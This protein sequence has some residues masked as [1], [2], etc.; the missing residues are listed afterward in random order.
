MA[1]GLMVVGAV[2]SACGDPDSNTGAQ[3]A[4]TDDTSVAST[5]AS[6]TSAQQVTV[7]LQADASA[8]PAA[9][10]AAAEFL[11]DRLIERGHEVVDFV[12]A[13]TTFTYT[14]AGDDPDAV[15]ELLRVGRVN[16]RAVEACTPG[17]PAGGPIT[18]PADDGS[19]DPT[20]SGLLPLVGGGQ[21]IVRPAAASGSVFEADAEAQII[22]G[23]WSVIVSLRPGADGLDPWNA[24]AT[25]C[26]TGADACPSKQLAI[27]V[28]GAIISAPT[29]N[30][31][32][33]AGDVQ[34]TGAFP[35]VEAR[36]LAD[37][38]NSGSFDV[39]LDV[40]SVDGP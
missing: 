6:S 7:V 35:E 29:V 10:T 27:E 28:N 39:A 17:D 24:L 26:F 13:G 30:Q 8:E 14:V 12:P 40:V 38:L 3:P 22:G 9:A 5:V 1:I 20:A 32:E 2:L 19:S 23:G 21:C 18:G 4:N 15:V 34:I 16:L 37:L 36:R 11:R 25:E 31:P 33:F